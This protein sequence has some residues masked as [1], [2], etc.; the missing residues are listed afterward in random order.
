MARGEAS[1]ARECC[2][3]SNQVRSPSA[4]V[5]GPRCRVPSLASSR[6]A[7]RRALA[8]PNKSR[9]REANAMIPSMNFARGFAACLAALMWGGI[10]TASALDYPT[11]PVRWI[12]PYTPGGG[13]DIQAR[14]IAQWPRDWPG[15]S[16]TL[17]AQP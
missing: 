4:L 9:R 7:T 3:F 15:K 6:K 17:E 1:G 11:R 14:I 16:V 8:E 12:V 2:D 13:T 10:G 5:R